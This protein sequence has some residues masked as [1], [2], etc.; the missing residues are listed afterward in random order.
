MLHNAYTHHGDCGSICIHNLHALMCHN[1][2]EDQM[3]RTKTRC[4]PICYS[5]QLSSVVHSIALAAAVAYSSGASGRNYADLTFQKGWQH[6]SPSSQGNALFCEDVVVWGPAQRNRYAM[7]CRVPQGGRDCV[8]GSFWH[9]GFCC[10]ADNAKSICIFSYASHA[11]MQATILYGT[12]QHK[13][14]MVHVTKDQVK[15]QVS[16]S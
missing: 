3:S 6:G 11:R 8:G 13:A 12:L 7:V 4:L 5:T 2:A 9:G 10:I 15:F 16:M 14:R 1:R